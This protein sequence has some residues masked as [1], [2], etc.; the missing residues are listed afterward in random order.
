LVE[1]QKRNIAQL[2]RIGAT[3]KQRWDLRE[4]NEKERKK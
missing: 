3:V 1:G 2:A 4:E